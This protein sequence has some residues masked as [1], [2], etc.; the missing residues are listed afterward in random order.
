MNSLEIFCSWFIFEPR[1]YNDEYLAL[2]NRLK[3]AIEAFANKTLDPDSKLISLL[4][5]AYKILDGSPRIRTNLL[6][7]RNEL[8]QFKSNTGDFS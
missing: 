2:S 3:W 7:F 8:E 6:T 1:Y 4:L 5:K